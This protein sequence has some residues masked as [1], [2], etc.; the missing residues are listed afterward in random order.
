MDG[1]GT[2]GYYQNLEGWYSMFCNSKLFGETFD[3]REGRSGN[4][5]MYSPRERHL[6]AKD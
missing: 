3:N 6:K 1:C 5:Y 4:Y 2:Q